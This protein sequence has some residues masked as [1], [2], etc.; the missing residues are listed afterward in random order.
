V[1]FPVYF[2]ISFCFFLSCKNNKVLKA[3]IDYTRF[4][5]KNFYL[6]NGYP[7]DT[8]G[9]VSIKI[10]ERLDTFYQWHNVSDCNGCGLYMSRLADSTY[11]LLKESGFVY[12][13]EP[14]S[15]YQLTISFRDGI[16]WPD[17]FYKELSIRDTGYIKHYIEAGEFLYDSIQWLRKSEFSKILNRPFVI[18]C[19]QIPS[20]YRKNEKKIV[21]AGITR[22]RK[23][24]IKF[25]A[26]CDAQDTTG[27]VDNMYKAFL[28][29]RI[30]EK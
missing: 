5:D 8:F 23:R 6:I 20:F 15:T 25:I 22:I 12:L 7:L 3:E 2:F 1:K 14:D 13:T 28:S 19:Y 9:Q 4:Y 10:P 17:S 16:D 27:F 21:L 18:Y 11:S 30:D 29:I 26:E 24:Q